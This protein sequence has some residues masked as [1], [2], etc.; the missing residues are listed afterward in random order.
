MTTITVPGTPTRTGA[1]SGTTLSGRRKP[2][3]AGTVA[4]YVVLVVIA[5]GYI[6]PFLIQ[7]ATSF[8]T[9]AEA[10]QN[11]LSLF[12]TTWTTAAYEKLFTGS[13]FPLWL[14]NSVIVTVSPTQSPAAHSVTSPV[15]CT[16][17]STTSSPPAQ[18]R[19]V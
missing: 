10:A 14:R 15:S 13:D 16:T 5:I 6:Y 19:T 2:R 18:E 1:P 7:V 4:V 3:R 9:D 8:K 11:A 12:P 17:T